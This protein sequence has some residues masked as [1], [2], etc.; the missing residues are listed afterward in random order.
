MK[1]TKPTPEPITPDSIAKELESVQK[2]PEGDFKAES[3]VTPEMEAQ[4]AALNSNNSPEA[5]PSETSGVY[6]QVKGKDLEVGQVVA[7]GRKYYSVIEK[8]DSYGNFRS[9]GATTYYP[10]IQF[11]K[12]YTVVKQDAAK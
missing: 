3:K 11:D 10:A 1:L 12:T 4:V 5:S 2:N 9:L 6:S 8:T 7:M